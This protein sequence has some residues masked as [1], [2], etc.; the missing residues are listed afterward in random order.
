MGSHYSY[1]YYHISSIIAIL[2]IY[3]MVIIAI[4]NIYK[5][6]YTYIYIILLI[7][8]YYLL[9]IIYDSY[10]SYSHGRF[11]AARIHAARCCHVAEAFASHFGFLEILRSKLSLVDTLLDQFSNDKYL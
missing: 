10:M 4:T 11:F 1:I 7:T 3:Y 2:Y 6:P 9:Y 5:F 8:I